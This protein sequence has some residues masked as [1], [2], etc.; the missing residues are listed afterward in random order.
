M[1]CG[2]MRWMLSSGSGAA[3][4]PFCSLVIGGARSWLDIPLPWVA[5]PSH[6]RQGLLPAAQGERLSV[7]ELLYA[8]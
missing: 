8:N 1:C 6:L 5:S 3:V 4:C 2:D 7:R